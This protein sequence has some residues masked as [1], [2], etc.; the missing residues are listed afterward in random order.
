MNIWWKPGHLLKLLHD[1]WL[2]LPFGDIGVPEDDIIFLDVV[3][4]APRVK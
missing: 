4:P 2:G 1:S 3:S